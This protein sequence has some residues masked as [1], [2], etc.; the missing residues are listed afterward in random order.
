MCVWGTRIIQRVT[1]TELVV[2]K[3]TISPFDEMLQPLLLSF[4]IRFLF[5]LLGPKGKA[6]SYHEIGRAIATLMSDEVGKQGKGM[7]DHLACICLNCE[8]T[9]MVHYTYSYV[10][11]YRMTHSHL[12]KMSSLM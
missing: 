8:L 1:T 6:K 2:D 4:S 3:K 11:F 12:W 5:I 10:A 9:A 7:W